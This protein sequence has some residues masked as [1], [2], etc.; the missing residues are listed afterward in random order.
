MGA[1]LARAELQEALPLLARRMPGLARNGDIKWKPSTFGIWGRSDCPAV[2]AFVAVT[3]AAPPEP[4]PRRAGAPRLRPRRTRVRLASSTMARCA[5]GVGRGPRRRWP[6]PTGPAGPGRRRR[7]G[8]LVEPAAYCARVSAG[9]AR[10]AGPPAGVLGRRATRSAQVVGRTGAS[11]PGR[12]PGRRPEDP[13]TGTSGRRRRAPSHVVQRGGA[14]TG[15]AERHGRRRVEVLPAVAGEPHL[16][17]GVGVVGMHLIEVGDRVEAPGHVA[18]GLTGGDAERCA[19]SRRARWRSAR[20]SRSGSE[21]EFVHG[22]G[23]GRQ[24]R[25]VLRVVRVRA[26]PVNERLHLV[27]GRRVVGGDGRARASTRG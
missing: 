26:D 22:V 12:R 9:P 14:G 7:P 20:R 27:V 4:A 25:D 3:R 18:D 17:P 11:A 21:E 6:R 5:A 23:A 24:G 19:A 16:D 2:H 13:A 10:V 8:E 1:A 15:G